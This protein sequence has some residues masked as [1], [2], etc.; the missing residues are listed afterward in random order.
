[1]RECALL[2]IT[3]KIFS[4]TYFETRERKRDKQRQT[5]RK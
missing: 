5:D 3:N 1:M 4:Y 2:W